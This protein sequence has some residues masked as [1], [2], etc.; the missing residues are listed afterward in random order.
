MSPDTKFLTQTH[1]KTENQHNEMLYS[2]ST[3]TLGL[4]PNLLALTKALFKYN[5]YI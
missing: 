3:R 1:H 5:K 4:G 2:F